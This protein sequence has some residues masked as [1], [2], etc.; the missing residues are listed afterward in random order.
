MAASPR[1]V[2]ATFGAQ[3]AQPLVLPTLRP[4]HKPREKQPT[5]REE[6]ALPEAR[7]QQWPPLP[8]AARPSNCSPRTHR[9]TQFTKAVHRVDWRLQEERGSGQSHDREVSVYVCERPSNP[10]A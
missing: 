2:Y 1:G 8:P 5:Q 3:Q 7:R 10:N 4:P 9:C 6:H